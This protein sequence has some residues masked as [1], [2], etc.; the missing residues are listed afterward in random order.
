M[1]D[2]IAG[3]KHM[4]N[5]SLV[6]R[7]PADKNDGR[8]RTDKL[9]NA[10]FK[11]TV[12]RLLTRDQTACRNTRTEFSNRLT[13]RLEDAGL[14]RHAQVIV[15]AETD[16]LF[17]INRCHVAR[18]SFVYPEEGVGH[19]RL[20]RDFQILLQ[21]KVVGRL[22]KNKILFRQNEFTGPRRVFFCLGSEML[23]NGFDD[24]SASFH[25][26]QYML[27]KTAAEG[28]FQGGDDFDAFQRV[29]SKFNDIRI[30]IKLANPFPA[31]FAYLFVDYLGNF[32]G[33]PRNFGPTYLRTC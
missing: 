10:S 8:F 16:V 22:G 19:A 13:C 12:D 27:G 29:E 26:G 32:G 1:Q 28:F 14:A 24:F 5:D 33:M 9:G 30:P 7:V 4:A 31:D 11:L 2:Q 17:P 18:N 3:S 6:G 25:R 23:L 21:A 20:T 15:A